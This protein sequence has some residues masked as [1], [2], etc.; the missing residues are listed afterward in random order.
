MAMPS[1]RRRHPA[2]VCAVKLTNAE[3]RTCGMQPAG[4]KY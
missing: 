3:W 1:K 4:L 2:A